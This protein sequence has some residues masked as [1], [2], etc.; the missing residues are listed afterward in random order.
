MQW[1]DAYCL[2]KPEVHTLS[3]GAARPSDFKEH[4]EAVRGGVSS[5]EVER[6]E[7]GI[8]SE[9]EK[10]LG[11]DWL[12]HWHEGIPH[13]TKIPGEVNVEEILRLYTFEKGL[14]LTDWAKMR[15]N[16]LGN[17]N[18]WFPGQQAQ[19]IDEI[20]LN[21]LSANRF[22]NDIPSIL[23]LAHMAYVDPEKNSRLSEQ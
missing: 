22:S 2:S 11:S 8:R 5:S 4:V 10:R 19:N 6:I 14:D 17:A 3:L 9:M 20:D 7:L 23:K 16:L 13:Y 18:H 21:I 1:H 15:Y 12:N